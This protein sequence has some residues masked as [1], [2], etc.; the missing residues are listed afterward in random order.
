[1]SGGSTAGSV[2]NGFMEPAEILTKLTDDVASGQLDAFCAEL[3]VDL[4]VLFGSARRDVS[5]ANTSTSPTPSSPE[6]LRSHTS[7]S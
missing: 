5:N 6:P 7:M 4:L 3:G 2:C 1:M